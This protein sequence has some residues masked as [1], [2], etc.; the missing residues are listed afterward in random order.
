MRLS[1]NDPTEPENWAA[2]V[3]EGARPASQYNKPPQKSVKFQAFRAKQHFDTI[4][5]L[6]G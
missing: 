1:K 4:K 3:R 5:M 2:G 6:G